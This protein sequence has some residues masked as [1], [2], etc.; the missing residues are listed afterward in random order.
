[1]SDRR[2]KLLINTFAVGVVIAV[3]LFGWQIYGYLIHGVWMPIT[4]TKALSWIHVEW[5][6]S[7]TALLGVHN[8]L[9]SF[10]LAFAVFAFSLSSIV[11]LKG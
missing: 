1:M 7:P 3:G 5:A 11:F 6:A 9:D 10:S 8:I 4:I 2:D